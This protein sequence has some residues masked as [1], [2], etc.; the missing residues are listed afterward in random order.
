M[1][2]TPALAVISANDAE[3]LRALLRPLPHYGSQSWLVFDGGRAIERGIWPM[4]DPPVPVTL[5]PAGA[6]AAFSPLLPGWRG[7]LG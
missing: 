7:R 5:L 3:A 1:P 4:I 2:G 6:P